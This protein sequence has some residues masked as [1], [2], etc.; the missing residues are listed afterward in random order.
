MIGLEY[1][2]NAV[3]AL[4][5]AA[6]SRQIP[7]G[8][9]IAITTNHGAG[10]LWAPGRIAFGVGQ[11]AG[12]DKVQALLKCDLTSAPQCFDGCCRVI[13]H[14]P[15]GVKGCEVQRYISP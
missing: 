15:V 3:L 4:S 11:V 14:L 9:T 13:Q 5:T 12:I 6:V 10:A 8:N 1:T 2:R 7:F